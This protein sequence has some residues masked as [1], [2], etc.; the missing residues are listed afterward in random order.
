MSCFCSKPPGKD[1]RK[2]QKPRSY[3]DPLHSMQSGPL[4]PIPNPNISL[5]LFASILP[6]GAHPTPSSIVYCVL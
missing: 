3:H 1:P 4:L 6:I 5:T 2:E